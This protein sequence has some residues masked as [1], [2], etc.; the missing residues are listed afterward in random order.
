MKLVKLHR[1]P[2]M[3]FLL[4]AYR[5]T[6]KLRNYAQERIDKSRVSAKSSE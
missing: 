6:L 5:L 2:V 1:V 3:L 4:L